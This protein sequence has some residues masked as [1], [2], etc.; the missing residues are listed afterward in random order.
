MIFGDFED[1]SFAFCFYL[2]IAMMFTAG[3]VVVHVMNLWKRD[4]GLLAA[5]AFGIGCLFGAVIGIAECASGF[6]WGFNALAVGYL[7]ATEGLILGTIGLVRQSLLV[8]KK[9]V[10]RADVKFVS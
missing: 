1:V 10:C 8:S 5:G 4:V 3:A 6:G 2:G 7:M 9:Q